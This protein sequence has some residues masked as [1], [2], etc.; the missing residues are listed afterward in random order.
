MAVY[1][2]SSVQEHARGEKSFDA[3]FGDGAGQVRD[4]NGLIDA[5]GARYGEDF[6]EFILGHGNC[7]FL[8]NGGGIA[9]TGGL[10]TPLSPGDKVEILPFVHGG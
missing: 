2:L 4:L 9:T 3:D 6:R 5:L 8:V 7:F 10:S 1:F